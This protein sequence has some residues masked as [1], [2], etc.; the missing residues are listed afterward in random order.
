MPIRRTKIIATLGPSSERAEVVSSLLD[1]GLNCARLN[2][3]H[4]THDNHKNLADTAR[5]LAQEKGLVFGIHQDLQGPKIRLGTLPVEGITLEADTMA[6]F[7]TA[8]DDY[9]GKRIPLGYKKLHEEVR[10]GDRVLL[11]DGLVQVKVAD[12]S[13]NDIHCIVEVGGKLISH[14]AFNVPGATLSV[15]SITAKDREDLAYG[16]S[17]IHPDWIWQSFVKIPDDVKELRALIAAQVPEDKRPKIF[18]KIEKREALGNLDE[19]AEVADGL[20]VARGDLAVEMEQEKVPEAQRLIIDTARSRG[21]P[22]VVATQ[23]LESMLLNP[24]PT[25]AEVSDIAHAVFDHADATYLSN[26]TASGKYPV[27]AVKVMAATIREA[28]LSPYDDVLDDRGTPE[29]MLALSAARL[30]RSVEAGAIVACTHSGRTAQ[31]VAAHR[32][33]I[34]LLAVTQSELVERQLAAVWGVEPVLVEGIG[35]HRLTVSEAR[36][37]VCRRLGKSWRGKCVVLHGFERGRTE[38]ASLLE[39]VTI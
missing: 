32:L 29:S 23:M 35:H 28:E 33:E 7:T 17:E 26:E 3:S 34:P 5:K 24:R 18:V 22:V 36:E 19:I 10:A 30:A 6:V 37:L 20:V 13:G 14:K 1:A 31:N 25:R 12:I 27:E 11:D 9:D 16:L 2:F 8:R 39:L 21:K 4:G 15:P 38:P